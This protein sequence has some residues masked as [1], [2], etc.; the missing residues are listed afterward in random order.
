MVSILN[1]NFE[2]LVETAQVQYGS[3]CSPPFFATKRSPV[4]APVGWI[5]RGGLTSQQF[6]NT[7]VNNPHRSHLGLRWGD[8]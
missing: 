7:F 6:Q 1:K 8:H 4:G 2:I 5:G 3:L